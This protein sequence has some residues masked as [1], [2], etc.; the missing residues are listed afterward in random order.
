MTHSVTIIHLTPHYVRPHRATLRSH[1]R[2]RCIPSRR[3]ISR[4]FMLCHL[5]P[6]YVTQLHVLRHHTMLSA[7]S[8]VTEIHT[9]SFVRQK[10]SINNPHTL[11]TIQ[12]IMKLVQHLSLKHCLS[13]FTRFSQICLCSFPVA[14]ALQPFTREE[15][16]FPLP[17][18]VELLQT[19]SLRL[20][21]KHW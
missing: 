7:P 8:Q 16:A 13:R 10:S 4:N 9:G 20:I 11:G 3:S 1:A 14:V 5:I 19:F 15:C 17:L 21:E 18:D 2:S 6:H 12:R